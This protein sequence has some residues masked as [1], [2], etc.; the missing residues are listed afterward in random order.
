ML[1]STIYSEFSVVLQVYF[2]IVHELELVGIP[3]LV[4]LAVC[5]DAL[6]FILCSSEP[7]QFGYLY[8]GSSSLAFYA[9]GYPDLLNLNLSILALS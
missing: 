1:V 6:F 5:I 7:F 8:A 3:R 4:A 9:F 2:W